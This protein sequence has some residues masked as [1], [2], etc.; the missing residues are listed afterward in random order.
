MSPSY[1]ET[2]TDDN[3]NVITTE[4]TVPGVQNIIMDNLSVSGDYYHIPTISFSGLEYGTYKVKLLASASSDA[5]TGY[6]RFEYYLDGV[7]VYNPLNTDQTEAS[8]QVKEGYGKELNAKFI[9]RNLV[10]EDKPLL[11]N[12]KE[13]LSLF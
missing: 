4:Q 2:T 11:E 12:R 7:R 6:K 8:E 9:E 3:G 5:A 13:Q 1:H 10:L